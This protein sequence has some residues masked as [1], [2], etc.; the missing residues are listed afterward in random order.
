MLKLVKN[1]SIRIKSL[2][3]RMMLK[4]RHIL[5]LVCIVSFFAAC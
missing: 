3:L 1:C 5:F 2:F 4:Y